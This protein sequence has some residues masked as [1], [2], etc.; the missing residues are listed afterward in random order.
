MQ[1]K[2]VLSFDEKRSKT[3]RLGFEI[4]VKPEVPDILNDGEYLYN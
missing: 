2:K 4:L 1:H 3:C